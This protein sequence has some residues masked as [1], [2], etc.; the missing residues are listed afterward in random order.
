MLADIPIAFT[1]YGRA[2]TM[3]DTFVMEVIAGRI[4]QLKKDLNFTWIFYYAVDGRGRDSWINNS[5]MLADIP[6]AFTNYG[7]AETMRV[8][9]AADPAVIYL[10]V[11][12]NDFYP[13]TDI[14]DFRKTYFR[15]H[16]DK[17]IVTNI[18]RNQPRKDIPRTIAAFAKF[19]QVRPHSLLYLHMNPVDVGGNVIEM[20]KFWGLQPDVD[21]M[22][23]KDFNAY[24]GCPVDVLNKIYNASDVII[25]TTLG[26]GWGLTA[27]EAMAA[28]RPVIIPDNTAFSEL[29]ADGRARLVKSG[30]DFF[31]LGAMDANQY[32]PLTDMGD[33]VEALTDC[34]D[35]RDK[36][37]VMADNA[38]NWAIG[39][40]W[41]N[42]G[43]QW[44]D[45]FEAA[46]RCNT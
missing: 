34:H 40:S 2:E 27:T 14:A 36:Y 10:G 4:R 13:I 44:L 43:K 31:C 8:N 17:F 6:I 12:C 21:F 46:S 11:N 28:R 33:L 26:E 25:S 39:L 23:P 1:N 30:S 3:L 41:D 29:G 16:A 20:A 9:A 7:R 35:N 22:A 18:N 15:D 19:R 37:R 45:V 38:Y 42:I 5:V 32:R 24:H